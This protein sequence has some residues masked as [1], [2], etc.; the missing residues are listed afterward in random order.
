MSCHVCGQ[1]LRAPLGLCRTCE[2]GL[3][4]GAQADP[5]QPLTAHERNRQRL[6]AEIEAFL[7]RGGQV[8]T[9]GAAATAPRQPF[10]GSAGTISRKR[11]L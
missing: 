1:P 2:A 3:V 6:A 7:A 11:Q 9:V 8:T 10:R 4:A 5:E